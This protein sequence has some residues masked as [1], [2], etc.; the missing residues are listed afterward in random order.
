MNNWNGMEGRSDSLP[1]QP[2]W[3]TYH[4]APS[5]AAPLRI[6]LL[7]WSCVQFA[8]I[9]HHLQCCTKDDT[10]SYAWDVYTTTK[11]VSLIS[12]YLCKCLPVSGGYTCFSARQQYV[13]REIRD[14]RPHIS[15]FLS[16]HQH[17][18]SRADAGVV[19]SFYL[20]CFPVVTPEQCCAALW[21]G[22]G[23]SAEN[24]SAYSSIWNRQGD[25]WNHT[26]EVVV[27]LLMLVHSSLSPRSGSLKIA[28]FMPFWPN[29]HSLGYGRCVRAEESSG[30]LAL[31]WSEDPGVWCWMARC[32]DGDLLWC[33]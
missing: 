28:S 22:E 30:N 21:S 12:V 11:I 17:G 1:T 26:E 6:S 24:R 33:E 7:D 10:R 23:P 13:R 25:H 3:C 5:A 15:R 19:S 27:F 8:D 9:I 4:W 31:W 14:W 2:G 20:H 32:V 16:F 29:T 18:S